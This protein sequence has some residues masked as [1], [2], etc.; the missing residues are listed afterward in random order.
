MRDSVVIGGTMVAYQRQRSLENRQPFI[1]MN[2]CASR[3][4]VSSV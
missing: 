4:G 3:A 1:A 2:Y